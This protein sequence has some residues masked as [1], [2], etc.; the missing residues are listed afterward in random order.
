MWQKKVNWTWED[1][2]EAYDWDVY[3]T[4]T[5]SRHD[6]L[7]GNKADAAAKLWRSCLN[8]LDHT[9]YGKSRSCQRRFDRVAFRHFGNTA[10]NPH[11]HLLAKSPINA[12]EFCIAWNAIWA[13]KFDAAASPINN[14]IAPMLTVKGATGYSQHEEFKQDIGSFD[15]RLTYINLG[16][17][18]HVRTDVIHKLYAKAT[19]NNLIKARLALPQ[20]IATTQKNF[21][22]REDARAAAMRRS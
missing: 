21:T 3:A 17:Q 10:T 7:D 11:V 9:L 13:S 8:T 14:S 22:R 12:N 18:H 1:W 19:R 5:F 4:L 15:D 2:M 6:L 16:D 20:H